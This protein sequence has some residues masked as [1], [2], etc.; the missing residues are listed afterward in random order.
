ME[1]NDGAL[2]LLSRV[3]VMD[4]ANEEDNGLYN[5]SFLT[6]VISIS[7]GVVLAS[8][9]GKI[10]FENTLDARLDVIFRGKLP[11]IRKLL[12]SQ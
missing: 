10:V 1:V 9:D 7:G 4:L 3:G 6:L 12:F 8:R 11:E 2:D 5:L